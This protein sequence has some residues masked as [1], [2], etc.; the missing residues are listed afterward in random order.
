METL[1]E[2]RYNV[3]PEPYGN[4]VAT[5]AWVRA[6]LD[7]PERKENP[8]RLSVTSG[9][10]TRGS[11]SRSLDNMETVSVDVDART[12]IPP[13]VFTAGISYDNPHRVHPTGATEVPSTRVFDDRV[14][15]RLTNWSDDVT[16]SSE[17][18]GQRIRDAMKLLE[19]ASWDVGHEAMGRATTSAD[20][21]HA[22][23]D[24]DR[25]PDRDRESSDRDRAS[26]DRDRAPT[27]D[28]APD[29]DRAPSDRDRAPTRDRAF[30]RDR[31][32][33]T[34]RSS[35]SEDNYSPRRRIKVREFDGKGSFETFYEHFQICA[36]YNRWREVDRLAHL[37]SALVG[38][39][40][41]LLWDTPSTE[42]D[43][44]AKLA[45]LLRNRFGGVKQ[46]DKFRMELRLRRRQPGETL[47]QLHQSIRC[48]MALAHP[49][50][51][52]DEREAIACD[53]YVDALDDPDFALK[54]RERAPT[55]LDDALRISLQLEAWSRDAQRQRG[56]RQ[57]SQKTSNDSSKLRFVNVNDDSNSTC[58]SASSDASNSLV[59]NVMKKLDELLCAMRGNN[60][61]SEPAQFKTNQ[62]PFRKRG[63]GGPPA[64]ANQQSVLQLR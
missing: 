24:R 11:D 25:A 63:R 10:T 4:F 16:T 36:Q 33:R 47:S 53:Y 35:S 59:D 1:D 27:R 21:D 60:A 23:S 8:A 44:V 20:R 55:T 18:R 9:A 32:R 26:S 46:I 57:P 5:P 29:R 50:L 7:D 34:G 3:E 39:A 22:S 12:L 56:E 62:Q 28:R 41:Q 15:R 45:Q 40:G 51:K 37:K 2:A 58:D 17:K 19:E 48:L 38:D 61:K 6:S 52:A 64:I 31:R 54:V 14:R 42:T 43:T 13:N 49:T 30:S